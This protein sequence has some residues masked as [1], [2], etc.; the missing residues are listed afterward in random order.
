MMSIFKK[1]FAIKIMA[2][3]LFVCFQGN[4]AIGILEVNG[5]LCPLIL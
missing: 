5:N 2:I 3:L 1:N 4:Q